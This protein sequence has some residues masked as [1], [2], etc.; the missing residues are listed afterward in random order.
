MAKTQD[1][2]ALTSRIAKSTTKRSI[3]AITTIVRHHSGGQSGDFNS[4][5]SYWKSKGWTKG[6]YHEIIL[7]DGTRQI[8]YDPIYPTNGVGGQNSY[9]YHI[10]LVGNGNFTEAQEKAWTEA[11]LEA[12]KRFKVANRN[13]KGHNEMPGANTACPGINM[14]VVRNRLLSNNSVTTPTRDYMMNGDTGAKV[15]AYQS[16]LNKQGYK[17]VVD[18][19]FGKATEDAT[20]DFQR[21]NGL[22]VDGIAGP[23]TLAALAKANEPKK[24]VTPV[25]NDKPKVNLNEPSA[26]AKKEWEIGKKH[27]ILQGEGERP[28]DPATREEV[29]AMIVRALGLK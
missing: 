19:I 10:C 21:K 5:W 3:N 8:C 20:K 23:L 22:N 13:V 4:F 29:N 9:T 24:E 14:N 7:R 11:C 16:D 27:G 25:A 2:R 18:G 28:K 15:S 17:L 6:G 12:Q 26:W 1:L